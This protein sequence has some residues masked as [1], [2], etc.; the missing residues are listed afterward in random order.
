MAE[1][2][3]ATQGGQ[4]A[5]GPSAAPQGP[6]S[7]GQAPQAP[8]PHPGQQAQ[9]QGTQAFIANAPSQQAPQ[10]S[11]GIAQPSTP[12]AELKSTLDSFFGT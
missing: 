10:G 5:P 9:P 8:F 1:A 12:D 11:F 3:G 2:N 7:P 6:A 4:P